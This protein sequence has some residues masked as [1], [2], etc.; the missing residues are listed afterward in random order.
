MNNKEFLKGLA[1]KLANLLGPEHANLVTPAFPGQTSPVTEG[2]QSPLFKNS[3]AST[4]TIPLAGQSLG[5]SQTKLT[6]A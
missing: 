3:P 5:A 6:T 1:E 2:S 4:T